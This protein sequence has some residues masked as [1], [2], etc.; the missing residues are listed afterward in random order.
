MLDID[1]AISGM[2]IIAIFIDLYKE[3]TIFIT[4]QR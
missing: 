1:K 3:I 2:W 4:D